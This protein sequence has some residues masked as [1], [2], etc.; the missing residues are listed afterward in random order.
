MVANRIRSCPEL[1]NYILIE[2]SIIKKSCSFDEI[3]KLHKYTSKCHSSK[4]HSNS[5][6]SFLQN[7]PNA[8]RK[9]RI[10]AIIKFLNSVY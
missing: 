8:T 3:I 5:Y 7:N 9:Q 10:N 4:C 1:S 2:N 6:G